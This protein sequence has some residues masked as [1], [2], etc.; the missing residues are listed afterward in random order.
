[1]VF[2]EATIKS[3][4][5][6]RNS[7]SK[8]TLRK[9][10][11]ADQQQQQQQQEVCLFEE[12]P[13]DQLVH[14]LEG[15]TE[16]KLRR[17]YTKLLNAED[18]LK[19]WNVD[20]PSIV[21]VGTVTEE[22]EKKPYLRDCLQEELCKAKQVVKALRDLEDEEG[23]KLLKIQDIETRNYFA[24]TTALL[25]RQNLLLENQNLL[26]ENQNLL[27]ENQKSLLKIRSSVATK[28]SEITI[29]TL[30]V[31]YK[32]KALAGLSQ[33]EVS[34]S[35]TRSVLTTNTE[36][37]CP[38]DATADS[39]RAEGAVA[40][41]ASAFADILN[42]PLDITLVPFFDK[43]ITQNNPEDHPAEIRLKNLADALGSFFEGA[44]AINCADKQ[45]SKN[46]KEGLCILKKLIRKEDLVNKD[47]K[48]YAPGPRSHEK[49]GTQPIF[50]LLLRE[51]GACWE[52]R[53]SKGRSPVKGDVHAEALIPGTN[54]RP[55]RYVDFVLQKFVRWDPVLFDDILTT[56]MEVKPL[57]RK[58]I[59]PLTLWDEARDQ[60]LSHLAKQIFVGFNFAGYGVPC[61]ATGIVGN[62][63]AIQIYHLRYESVGTPEACLKLYI[64]RKLPLL[65]KDC[66]EKWI[67]KHSQQDSYK[68]P[69]KLLENF[70]NELYSTEKP[71]DK[72]SR[73]STVPEGIRALFNLVDMPSRHLYGLSI[74]THGK[75]LG[76]QVGTGAAAVV[77][78]R[79]DDEGKECKS[80]VKVSRFGIKNHIDNE[81]QFLSQLQEARHKNISFLV[82]D[83]EINR[84]MSVDITLGSVPVAMPA[85][86]IGP[87]GT[88]VTQ[89]ISLTNEIDDRLKKI[90][91]DIRGALAFLHDKCI[92]HLDVNP[93]NII[94]VSA[95]NE[96]ERAILIDFTIAQEKEAK[97][98]GFVGTPVYSHRE[99]FECHLHSRKIWTA[100]PKH[101]YA[102]LGY[103]LAFLANGCSRP[104]DIGK[105]PLCYQKP[106]EY[107]KSDLEEVMDERN[108]AAIAVFENKS[109]EWKKI[110]KELLD[111]NEQSSS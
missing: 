83:S 33:A 45:Y 56:P 27:L 92:V 40:E 109:D 28:L 110:I 6:D 101:D 39:V 16:T 79:R 57:F 108:K 85:I 88:P 12:D 30:H 52:G 99:I 66:F 44:E 65:Q 75:F 96:K 1:M 104:Y 7:P 97:I 13:D 67:S 100:Q 35:N 105:Y 69:E 10:K 26:L 23:E 47:Q 34:I 17:H 81:R 73:E 91:N 95:G 14:L 90:H 25:K 77:F 71:S 70:R 51:I 43:I 9:R 21:L 62:I 98:K 61:H 8:S 68:Y 63:A 50:Q 31:S 11:S 59:S 87:L 36:S 64:S 107:Q 15:L 86:E 106:D 20:E 2:P 53:Q 76:N 4:E 82:K 3:N 5:K 42:D 38:D 54:L 22:L 94:I 84:K 72:V 80:V 78:R 74:E 32:L 89:L 111:I 55:K 37:N 41:S 18:V 46:V 93:K 24:R 29:S 48:Y 19:K 49:D 58:G 60:V 102:G 103:T